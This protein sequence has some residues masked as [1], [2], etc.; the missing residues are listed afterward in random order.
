[1]I[2]LHRLVVLEHKHHLCPTPESMLLLPAHPMID[3]Q[4]FKHHHFMT[5]VKLQEDGQMKIIMPLID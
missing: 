4:H 5:Q 3:L 1:M 2:Q